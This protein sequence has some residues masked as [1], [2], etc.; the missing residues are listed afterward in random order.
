MHEIRSNYTL[1]KF[2]S[3]V[4]H[5]K[6]INSDYESASMF[7]NRQIELSYTKISHNLVTLKF[8]IYLSLY[9]YKVSKILSKLMDIYRER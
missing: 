1:C 3:Y 8:Y 4:I 7:I 2:T 6:N 5:K 9:R